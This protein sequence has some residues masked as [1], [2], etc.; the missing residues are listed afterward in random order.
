MIKAASN[1][2]YTQACKALGINSRRRCAAD[3]LERAYDEKLVKANCAISTAVTRSQLDQANK[4]LRDLQDALRIAKAGR[5]DKTVAATKSSRASSTTTRQRV[6]SHR[7]NPFS[8]VGSVIRLI[9]RIFLRMLKGIPSFVRTFFSV[10]NDSAQEVES[11]LGVPKLAVILLV[12]FV[13]I[14]MLHGCRI[15]PSN[16]N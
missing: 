9:F 8:A 11:T 5:S 1:M 12:L 6:R 15:S 13:L 2:T 10:F 14:G 16:V 7:H 4:N 3:V